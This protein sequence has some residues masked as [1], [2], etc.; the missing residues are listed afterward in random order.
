[1]DAHIV[2]K[3]VLQIGEQQMRTIQNGQE[4][5][6]ESHLFLDSRPDDSN[7]DNYE[8]QYR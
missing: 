8:K 3:T 4:V 7:E 5:E 6:T 2:Q 1:M